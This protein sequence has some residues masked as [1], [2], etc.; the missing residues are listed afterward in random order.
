[1][2]T[3]VPITRSTSNASRL[4][5]SDTMKAVAMAGKTSGTVTRLSRV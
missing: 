4:R 5:I 1:M 2:F 3:G